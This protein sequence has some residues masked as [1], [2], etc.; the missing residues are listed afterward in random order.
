MRDLFW[1]RWSGKSFKLRRKGTR[2]GKGE[3]RLFSCRKANKQ[4]TTEN[5]KDL[6]DSIKLV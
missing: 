2:H 4:T 6:K 3:Q 5:V 1:I